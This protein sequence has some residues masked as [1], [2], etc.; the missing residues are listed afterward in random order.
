MI[1][2][3]RSV[4][5]RLRVFLSLCGPTSTWNWSYEDIW[6][7]LWGYFDWP[8]LETLCVFTLLSVSPSAVLHSSQ[9]P[10]LQPVIKWRHTHN[11]C[12]VLKPLASR[13]PRQWQ[14]VFNLCESLEVN[15]VNARRWD[16][17]WGE[18][19]RAGGGRTRRLQVPLWI[20]GRRWHLVTLQV[21]QCSPCW[22]VITEVT[23]SLPAE[24]MAL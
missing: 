12:L 21:Q 23:G 13:S 14:F 5:V 7:P 4:C 19:W 6:G 16:V 1:Q 2:D 18:M 15:T 10:S 11:V 20:T 9:L 17:K 8:S 24:E 3:S 22:G